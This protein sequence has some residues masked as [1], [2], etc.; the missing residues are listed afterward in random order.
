MTVSVSCF[1]HFF[2]I[3]SELLVFNKCGFRANFKYLGC[4]IRSALSN[5]R[6]QRVGI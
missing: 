2:I 4:H 5:W 6:I 3:V 1:T